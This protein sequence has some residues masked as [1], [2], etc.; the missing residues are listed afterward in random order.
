MT[1]ETATN[2]KKAFLGL[3]MCKTSAKT[4]FLGLVF[5][6]YTHSIMSR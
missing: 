1:D 6:I 2:P 5:A 3:I 4:A